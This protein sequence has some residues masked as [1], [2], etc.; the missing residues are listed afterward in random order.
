MG[1][2]EKIVIG[3]V[4]IGETK[5]AVGMVEESFAP[6]SKSAHGDEVKDQRT[7]TGPPPRPVCKCRSGARGQFLSDR[8]WP[9]F[10]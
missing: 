8:T 7:E 4:D 1:S 6:V 9:F 5:I 2:E 3:A 10:L